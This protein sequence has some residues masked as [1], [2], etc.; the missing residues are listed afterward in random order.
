MSNFI[1]QKGASPTLDAAFSRS[2]PFGKLRV[3][4]STLFWKQLLRW[5]ALPVSDLQRVYRRVEEVH[6]TTGCCSNDFSIHRLV[7]VRKNGEELPLLIGDSLYR[8]EPERLMEFIR[9]HWSGV[10]IGKEK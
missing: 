1:Y 9:Q 5:H 7:V 6:G 4:D 2:Q 8:H 3:S 10:A